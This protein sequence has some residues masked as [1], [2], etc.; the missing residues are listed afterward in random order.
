VRTHHWQHQPAAAAAALNFTLTASVL[1]EQAVPRRR[2]RAQAG[3]V[4]KLTLA[5]LEEAVRRPRAQAGDVPKLT[6]AVLEEQVVRR[7]RAGWR[8]S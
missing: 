8:R 2:P 5:V 1:E 4:P 7:P 3:D 6:L